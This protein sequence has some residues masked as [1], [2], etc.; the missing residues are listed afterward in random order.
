MPVPAEDSTTSHASAGFAQPMAA[1]AA[2]SSSPTVSTKGRRLHAGAGP[3][4]AELIEE[5][6]TAGFPEGAAGAAQLKSSGRKATGCFCACKRRNRPAAPRRKPPA[7]RTASRLTRT[8]EPWRFAAWRAAPRMSQRRSGSSA[9]M[10]PSSVSTGS[11]RGTAP[12]PR[13]SPTFRA[14]THDAQRPRGHEF[15]LRIDEAE[16]G[17]ARVFERRIERSA[18]ATF[19]RN[20]TGDAAELVRPGGAVLGRKAI[21]YGHHLMAAE[22]Q[23][24]QRRAKARD[25]ARRRSQAKAQ[26]LR[27]RAAISAGCW[28]NPCQQSGR[29]RATRRP[30]AEARSLR[31]S[32]KE[33]ER[34]CDCEKQIRD[35][36]KIH[37]TASRAACAA[38][39]FA[40]VSPVNSARM[41]RPSGGIVARAAAAARAVEDR[42]RGG[43][44]R[45][46]EALRRVVICRKRR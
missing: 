20:Q 15:S 22:L 30:H 24:E 21:E 46:A 13:R 1:P 12:R 42:P 10:R 27:A 23:V 36:H 32:G 28:R 16:Y 44:A 41:R 3:Q 26:R 7:A 2:A 35:L 33:Q 40:P 45:D 29:G 37:W 4:G 19:H 8:H 18:G 14:R 39:G 5:G 31:Y 9:A 11:A 43:T 34:G 25:S 38:T 6:L 17:I